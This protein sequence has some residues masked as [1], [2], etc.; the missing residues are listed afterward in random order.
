MNISG[1][2]Y[3]GTV[4]TFQGID[5][6]SIYLGSAGFATVT[7]AYGVRS[8]IATADATNPYNLYID[9]TAKN[10]FAGNVGIGTTN[11][12]E[13]LDVR[14]NVMVVGLTT[15]QNLNVTGVVTATTFLGNPRITQ[16]IKT[17]SYTLTSADAGE[18]IYTSVSGIAI[19]C[20]NS[21]FTAGDAVTIV[22]NSASS[23]N[24]NQGTSLT[25]RLSGTTSTGNRTL[26]AYG[27][28]TVL[29]VG[30]STAFVS[31]AG[32]S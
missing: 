28:A 19:T 3:T 5:I 15:T 17:A 22:N 29:Y 26:A 27:T 16:N 7:T 6:N 8:E 9:G 21:V 32:L 13:K 1:Y 18:H 25:L 12:L 4:T 23:I 24:I 31:G 11:A 30:V 20:P 10:Y 14:G 2:A